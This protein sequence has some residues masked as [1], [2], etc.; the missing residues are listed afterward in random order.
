MKTIW[1]LLKCPEGN[2]ADYVKEFQETVK[3]DKN[4][5]G[6]L[7]EV[8][9]FQCQRMMRY[10]GSWHLER[11]AVLPGYVFLSG[12]ETGLVKKPK[13]ENISLKPCEAPFLKCLCSE[14]NLVGMSRGVIKHGI[15]I[16][17]SGPLQGKEYLIRKIDR[18]K[19][20]AWL[21]IPFDGQKQQITVGL[22]IYEQEL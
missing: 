9:H 6:G 15:P 21:E 12:I 10:R 14:G 2:E 22:E 7:Q 4:R 19:R 11:R 20:T 13:E 3:P 5:M 17:T 18:H 16:V 1:Y 8:I